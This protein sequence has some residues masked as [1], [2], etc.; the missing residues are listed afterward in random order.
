MSEPNLLHQMYSVPVI[1]VFITASSASCHNLQQETRD[2]GLLGFFWFIFFFMQQLKKLH[3]VTATEI[4]GEFKHLLQ[5]YWIWKLKPKGS[6]FIYYSQF[7]KEISC[8][9]YKI[10]QGLLQGSAMK[11]LLCM[12]VFGN[13]NLKLDRWVPALGGF[14]STFISQFS[15][16]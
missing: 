3:G 9:F 10:Q 8:I 6:L 15:E 16:R 14:R 1:L 11:I 7:V 5:T 13:K 2:F 4:M 12:C